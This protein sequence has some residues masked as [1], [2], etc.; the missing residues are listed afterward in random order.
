MKPATTRQEKYSDPENALYLAFE[1][2][3]RTW[4]L[5]MTVGFGQKAR[6]RD[7]PAGDLVRLNTEIRQAKTRLGLPSQCREQEIDA[8]YE[9][10]YAG[11]KNPLDEG[12][13]GWEEEGV[14]PPISLLRTVLVAPITSSAHGAPSEVQ[15]GIDEGLKHDSVINLDQV[16][17][18]NQQKLHHLVG[19]LKPNKMAAVCRAL[20]IATGCGD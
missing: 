7:V 11:V 3:N 13:S 5:G 19:T 1:L 18:V 16:Q 9:S 8:Q 12:F 10:A 6:E 20:Q 17:T 14:W 2:S 15:V 4:K